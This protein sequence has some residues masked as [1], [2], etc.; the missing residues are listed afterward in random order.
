[1][2]AAFGTAA[3]LF[4]KKGNLLGKIEGYYD[5]KKKE[6]LINLKKLMVL[7]KIQEGLNH[8]KKKS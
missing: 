2:F 1:V 4:F 6:M 3:L 5:N 7:Q 8:L